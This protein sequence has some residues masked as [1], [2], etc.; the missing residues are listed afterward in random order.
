MIE[1]V[2]KLFFKDD[3]SAVEGIKCET[4][5]GTLKKAFI[6]TDVLFLA[7]V[8]IEAVKSKTKKVGSG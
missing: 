1:Q 6:Q 3:I 5:I 7:S 8:L 4:C 2:H